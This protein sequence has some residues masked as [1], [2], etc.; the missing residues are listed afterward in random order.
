MISNQFVE[1]HFKLHPRHSIIAEEATNEWL[2]APE[3][4]MILWTELSLTQFLSDLT[5]KA[6]ILEL[7]R[8]LELSALPASIGSCTYGWKD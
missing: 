3:L 5:E 7:F 6:Y 4:R 1:S 8:A 2:I